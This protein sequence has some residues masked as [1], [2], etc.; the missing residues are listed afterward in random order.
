ML[1]GINCNTLKYVFAPSKVLNTPSIKRQRQRQGHI[2]LV[3]GD[4]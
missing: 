2:M 4:S 3:Y 1:R